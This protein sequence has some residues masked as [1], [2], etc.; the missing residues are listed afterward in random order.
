MK[1][2]GRTILGFLI[3]ALIIPVF[4]LVSPTLSPGPLRAREHQYST[5]PE[6]QI[7]FNAVL[8][9][10]AQSMNATQLKQLQ[11]KL[12]ALVQLPGVL[13]APVSSDDPLLEYLQM[14]D[15]F[16]GNMTLMAGKIND[17]RRALA[18][19]NRPQAQADLTQLEELRRETKPLVKS[20]N[21]TLG[22]VA[23]DYEIDTTV[24]QNKLNDLNSLFQDYSHQIDQ[25]SAQLGTLQALVQTTLTLNS[26]KVAAFI[27]E[28]F[29]VYGYLTGENGSALANRNVTIYWADNATIVQTDADGKFNVNISYPVGTMAGRASIRAQFV[30]EG[31][32]ALLLL[33]SQASTQIVLVYY[34]SVI[35]AEVVPGAARPAETVVVNGNLRSSEGVPLDARLITISMD[36]SVLGNT[37]TINGGYFSF[38]FSVPATAENG[39]HV[40]DVRYN[41]TVDI[42]TPANITL[43]FVVELAGTQ[44]QFNLDR[45]SILSGTALTLNGTVT[46]DNGTI[47]NLGN[48]TVFVDNETY[49]TQAINGSFRIVIQTSIG[50]GLGTHSIMVTYTAS[51]PW[52][53][54]SSAIVPVY[55]YNTPI[56]IV[57]VAAVPTVSVLG[58][59]LAR[60][61][62]R[63]VV[64]VVPRPT[65]PLPIEK[66]ILKD[67]FTPKNLV[68]EVNV[69][70]DPSSRIRR[71][72]R[73]AQAL[74]NRKLSQPSRESE[75]HWEYY[76]RV[77]AQIPQIRDTFKRLVE[78]FELVE[79][80]P[81]PAEV[82]ESRE[83][84]EILL[85]LREQI[86]A[87]D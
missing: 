62:T 73:L 31:P 47:S 44:V 8:S 76:N 85:E 21:S 12:H 36:Q 23:D 41:A 28:P 75:T 4:Y 37:T 17:A 65:Q 70:L 18:S 55:V 6:A 82:A 50:L 46:F 14:L 87:A 86:E 67:E 66:P 68:F 59:Y 39:T 42:F 26:T 29:F 63:R 25:L 38:Q 30:P 34:P 84:T 24:Q 9:T 2:K 83:A 22:R 16:S 54:S 15:Q 27:T 81:E 48:V 78:L 7:D 71:S 49:S 80:G 69:D 64:K 13:N 33:P 74:I 3:L 79:Y 53:Q 20:L 57:L 61:R 1:L 10:L 45:A 40:L 56:I 11:G 52:V 5:A 19:G 77:S 43:P 35:S 51:E 58:V 32:D 72:F 60:R